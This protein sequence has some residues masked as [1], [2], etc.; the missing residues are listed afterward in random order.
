VHHR[1]NFVK[2]IGALAEN[3][4]QQVNLARRLPFEFTHASRVIVSRITHHA[5]P[6]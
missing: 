6:T 2:T 4:Q 5:S 3:I 1:L